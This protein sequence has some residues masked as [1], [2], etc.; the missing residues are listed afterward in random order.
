MWPRL[1]WRLTES[2][3]QEWYDNKIT[4]DKTNE[5]MSEAI[6]SEISKTNTRQ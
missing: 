3:M 1:K 2:E 4:R 6:F 5:A